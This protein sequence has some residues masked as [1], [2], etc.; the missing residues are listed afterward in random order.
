MLGFEGFTLLHE[1]IEGRLAAATLQMTDGE[2]PIA[3]K[4]VLYTSTFADGTVNY[5]C[6]TTLAP[7]E[8]EGALEALAAAVTDMGAVR[9]K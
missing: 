9:K 6:K 7:A 5:I 4:S 8:D 3:V 1:G 2:Q